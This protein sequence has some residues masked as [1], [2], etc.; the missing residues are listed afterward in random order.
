MRQTSRTS[1]TARFIKASLGT[2]IENPGSG[3]VFRGANLNTYSHFP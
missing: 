1:L 2:R 3:M